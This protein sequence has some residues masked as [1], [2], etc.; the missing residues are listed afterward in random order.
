[1]TAE[2]VEH[3]WLTVVEAAREMETSERTVRRLIATGRLRSVR[4]TTY[5]RHRIHRSEL[6]K[7]G[8]VRPS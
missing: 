2:V 3:E 5:G 7:F 4:F 6:A 1:M 8:Q